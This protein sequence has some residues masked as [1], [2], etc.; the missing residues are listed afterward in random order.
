MGG[1]RIRGS[2]NDW[3][4]YW[5]IREEEK[6]NEKKNSSHLGGI[7]YYSQC[8]LVVRR[9]RQKPEENHKKLLRRIRLSHLT[10]RSKAKT[11]RCT[12]NRNLIHVLFSQSDG[13]VSLPINILKP[14]S[15][16]HLLN[17]VNW[18]FGIVVIR[19]IWCV[20]LKVSYIN[21]TL[22]NLFLQSSF[23]LSNIHLN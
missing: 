14:E 2:W 20:S 5:Y 6:K 13:N 9:K 12:M 3:T 23:S 11:Q 10:K 21:R 4:V 15:T 17:Q 1:G 16:K 7:H 18:T 19:S 8:H 22:P